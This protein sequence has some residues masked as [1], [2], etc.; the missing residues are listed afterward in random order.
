MATPLIW[1]VET[2]A[3]VQGAICVQSHAARGTDMSLE[4]EP[5]ASHPDA[6]A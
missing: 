3:Q 5:A 2:D 4:P 1:E 6:F